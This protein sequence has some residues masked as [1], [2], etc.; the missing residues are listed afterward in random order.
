MNHGLK[1]GF[2]EEA[3]A[4]GELAMTPE[5]AALRSLFLPLQH[6]KMKQVQKLNLKRLSKLA[7]WVAA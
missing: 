4:F 2:A 1:V 6:L 5:S 3:K 7:Y